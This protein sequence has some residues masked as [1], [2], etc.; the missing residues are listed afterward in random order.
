M[1]KIS[2]ELES[3]SSC[4]PNIIERD[5]TILAVIALR[6]SYIIAFQK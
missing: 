2:I 4:M 1:D 3:V 5:G 6:L